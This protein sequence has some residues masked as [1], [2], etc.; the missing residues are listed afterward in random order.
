MKSVLHEI[1]I[2][3]PDVSTAS[4]KLIGTDVSYLVAI[5][6]GFPAYSRWDAEDIKASIMRQ[7]EEEEDYEM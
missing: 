3:N 2:R 5:R 4:K 1:G 6:I 7:I